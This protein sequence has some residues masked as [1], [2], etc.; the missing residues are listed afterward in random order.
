[1]I[2]SNNHSYI[3]QLATTLQYFEGSLLAVHTSSFMHPSV[4]RTSVH[5]I[6]QHYTRWRRRPPW[7]YCIHVPSGTD[8]KADRPAFLISNTSSHCS[9]LI[10]CCVPLRS[11]PFL[12]QLALVGACAPVVGSPLQNIPVQDPGC[13]MRTVIIFLLLMSLLTVLELVAPIKNV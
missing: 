12:G 8:S 5:R 9:P 1:M 11:A 4:V 7:S 10:S 13:C 6:N 2:Q 3:Y